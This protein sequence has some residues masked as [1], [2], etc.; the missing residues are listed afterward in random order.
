MIGMAYPL[1]RSPMIT[2]LL[3]KDDNDDLDLLDLR[4]SLNNP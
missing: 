2:N 3:Y 4:P 1:E